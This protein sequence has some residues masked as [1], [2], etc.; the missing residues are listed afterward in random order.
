MTISGKEGAIILGERIEGESRKIYELKNSNPILEM[1]VASA[2]IQ[3]HG[4]VIAICY[5]NKVLR[6]SKI[7][8]SE[9]NDIKIKIKGFV[10]NLGCEFQ[11]L[12][13]GIDDLIE[14]D[15]IICECQNCHKD[16]QNKKISRMSGRHSGMRYFFFG[17]CCVAFLNKAFRH[18][19]DIR[20]KK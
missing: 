8:L 9:K 4:G 20:L 15:E 12:L 7:N 13:E 1:N 6:E 14:G 11:H 19:R 10:E 18:I 16:K 2:K 3:S 17:D 5:V